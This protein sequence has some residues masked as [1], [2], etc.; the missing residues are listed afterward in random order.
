MC[1]RGESGVVAEAAALT[2]VVFIEMAIQVKQSMSVGVRTGLSWPACRLRPRSLGWSPM[3]AALRSLSG[4]AGMAPA[5]VYPSPAPSL[6]V[7]F[8]RLAVVVDR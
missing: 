1:V 8:A 2:S 4:E 6:A 7:E 3:A 5:S